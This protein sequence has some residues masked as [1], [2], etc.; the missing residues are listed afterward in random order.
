MALAST[1]MEMDALKKALSRLKIVLN[2]VEL[3]T[4]A[5][6]SIKKLIGESTSLL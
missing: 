2:V 4:D 3:A 5:S 1:N 6:S